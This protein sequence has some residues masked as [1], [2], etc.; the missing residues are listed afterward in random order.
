M[1]TLS[2]V[3][4]NFKPVIAATVVAAAAAAKVVAAAAAAVVVVVVYSPRLKLSHKLRPPLQLH[5]MQ[6]SSVLYLFRV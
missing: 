6:D 3:D 1:A 2:S 5:R 4:P